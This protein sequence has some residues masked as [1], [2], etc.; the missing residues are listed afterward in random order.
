[1]SPMP[2]VPDVND[3]SNFDVA[4]AISDNIPPIDLAKLE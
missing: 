2:S 4:S 3:H 1:M